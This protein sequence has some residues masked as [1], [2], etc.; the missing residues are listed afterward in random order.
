MRNDP[1]LFF[2]ALRAHAGAQL[3]ALLVLAR[4]AGILERFGALVYFRLALRRILRLRA[5]LVAHAR[6]ALGAF[7]ALAGALRLRVGRLH[8]LAVLLAG[9]GVLRLRAV[10]VASALFGLG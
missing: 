2:A 10:E 3:V 8:L 6:A 9:L 5:H 1:G 4:F 7:L